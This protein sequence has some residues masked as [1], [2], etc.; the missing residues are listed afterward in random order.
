M[1]LEAIAV[2]NQ[3]LAVNKRL[4]ADA[5]ELRADARALLVKFRRHRFL[6]VSGGSDADDGDQVRALLRDFCTGDAPPKSYVGFSRGSACQACGGTINPGD[7]EYD[8]VTASAT[9][10]LDGRCYAVLIDVEST[11]PGAATL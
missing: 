2:A 1:Y 9:L 11:T 5:A 7:I 6:H 8:L 4:R 3:T 10:R